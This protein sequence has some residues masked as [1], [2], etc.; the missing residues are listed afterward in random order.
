V[1]EVGM[2]KWL[3]TDTILFFLSAIM[4][5]LEKIAWLFFNNWSINGKKRVQNDHS[6]RTEVI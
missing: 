3:P 6:D 2:D 5:I 4:F 1:E